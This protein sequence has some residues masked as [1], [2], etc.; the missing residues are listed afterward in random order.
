MGGRIRPRAWAAPPARAR[1][2]AREGAAL[3]RRSLGM[4]P[5]APPP[6]GS[7][8]PPDQAWVLLRPRGK[9]PLFDA[10][11]FCEGGSCGR[12]VIRGG[13]WSSAGGLASSFQNGWTG[14]AGRAWRCSRAG[15]G[16]GQRGCADPCKSEAEFGY[17]ALRDGLQSGPPRG[18]L[19]PYSHGAAG[20][21][22]W[23]DRPASRNARCKGRP[24]RLAAA[25]LQPPGPADRSGPGPNVDR[26]A[27]SSDS[28]G[29]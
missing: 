29:Q 19:R 6:Q 1:R 18:L 21:A 22:S 7:G 3:G 20:R 24:P 2:S 10:A 17:G 9:C 11:P 16:F 14:R 23:L 26:D 8:I 27:N 5:I 13:F 28:G 25:A 4:A 15:D 12:D